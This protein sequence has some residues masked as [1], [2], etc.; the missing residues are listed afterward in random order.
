MSQSKARR[1]LSVI[2]RCLHISA[3]MLL[4]ASLHGASLTWPIGQIGLAAIISGAAMFAL[5][6][7]GRTGRWREIAGFG[8]YGKLLVLLTIPL[9]PEFA[10]PAFWLVVVWS[11]FFS[12]A[13]ASFR[14]RK[15][16][17]SDR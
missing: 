14:H 4:G 1:W 3:V 16:M 7:S 5:D 8:V 6:L 11:S 2:L 9:A 13:P 15:L 17:G 12:H 10:K